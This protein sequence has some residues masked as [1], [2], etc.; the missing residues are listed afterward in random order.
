[1]TDLAD[2]RLRD[3]LSRRSFLIAISLG[4]AAALATACAGPPAQAPA[5][6]SRG[7]TPVSLMERNDSAPGRRVLDT[8]ALNLLR[9][10]RNPV[11][12]NPE[13]P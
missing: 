3:S 4:G 7:V 12:S 11:P 1:M 10:N 5:W 2:D 6:G 9:P 13:K 8:M